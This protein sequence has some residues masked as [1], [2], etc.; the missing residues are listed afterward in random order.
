M[1]SSDPKIVIRCGSMRYLTT[2]AIWPSED[3]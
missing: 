3:T 2:P 1:K